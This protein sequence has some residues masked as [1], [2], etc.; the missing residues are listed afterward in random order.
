MK[1]FLIDVV[2]GLAWGA[3]VAILLGVAEA[4]AGTCDHTHHL[5]PNN[6][7]EARKYAGIAALGTAVTGNAWAGFALSTAAAMGEEALERR[8]GHEKD[9]HC[10]SWKDLGMP[11]LGAAVG[12]TAVGLYIG[13]SSVQIDWRF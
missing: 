5:Q 2:T 1:R 4:N 7:L 12:A 13:P 10:P 6:R 8:H 9:T 11:V 3:V